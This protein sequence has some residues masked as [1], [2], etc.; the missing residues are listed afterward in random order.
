MIKTSYRSSKNNLKYFF[1]KLYK[2][3]NSPK[4]IPILCYHSVNDL[5]CY[6]S[7]S[8]STFNFESHLQY[9]SEY[10]EPIKLD[11]AIEQVATNKIKLHNQVVITFDDGY[12]DNYTQAFPLLMKYNIPAT[13][14]I[15]SNFIN[16]NLCLIDNTEYTSMSWSQIIDMLNS[17]IISI[18][19][20]THTHPIL[21][22][23]S[24]TNVIEELTISKDIIEDKISTFVSHFAFPNGQIND[25]PSNHDSLLIQTGYKSGSSTIWSCNNLSSDL[26][27]LKRIM[28][29]STDVLS[30]FKAKIHG[31]YDYLYYLQNS[32]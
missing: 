30:H 4:T 15:V 24:N 3:Y 9:I 22:R 5:S 16:K 23:I 12:I 28:I 29:S 18:G 8:I 14:F 2:F 32:K 21:S 10:L 17:G 1:S 19:S 13:F 25:L 7:D 27:N 20:H 26:Y 6:E 31:N 11:H